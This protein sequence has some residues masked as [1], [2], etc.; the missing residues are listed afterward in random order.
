MKKKLVILKRIS[1]TIFVFVFVYILWSTTYPLKGALPAE[2]FFQ[3]DPLVTIFTSISE[4]VILPGIFLSVAMLL[5]TALF[6]RFFCG[7]VCPLG[8]MIDFV[9]GLRKDKGYN[10]SKKV[11]NLR[12]VK[13]YILGIS[14]VIAFFGIQVVWP[15]DPIVIAARFISLNF[16][17]GLT[18]AVNGVF[19]FILKQL[20]RP[21][22]LL[23]FYRSLKAS[24]LGVEISYFPHTVIIFSFFAVLIGSAWFLKRSWCRVI[25][26]LGALYAVLAKLARLKRYT[27]GCVFCGKCKDKCPMAAINE[28]ITYEKS[29]CILCMDCIYNCPV[30]AT[31][32]SFSNPFFKENAKEEAKDDDLVVQNIKG[33]TRRNLLL[34][35]A[36]GLSP[37]LLNKLRKRGEKNLYEDIIIRPPGAIK[38]K[39]FL[40]RCIRCGNCMKVC[41]T[42]GLQPMVFQAGAEGV[43]TPHFI[44]ELGYCEYN[45]TLCGNVCPTGAIPKLTHSE[46]LKTRLGI[47]KID[48]NICLP[49]VKRQE[50]IVCEEHCPVKNKA[51]KLKEEKIDGKLVLRPYVDDDLCIGCGVCQTKCPVRPVRAIKILPI[52]ADRV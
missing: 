47:A 42:N 2:T 40:N 51:I 45:C 14:G 28:D 15:L 21:Q 33:L 46:K 29:E 48:R 49:W 31:R 52:K 5:L 6:A 13:F 22:L 3:L 41:V 37:L 50:C 20:N 27:Q 10:I 32:F 23:D 38:E 12:A 36:A 43:W 16:I 30:K 39:E 35:L 8:A 25:C 7:W 19:V 18:F 4:R 34:I 44:F 26:P 9:G 17:P 24:L 1:Q 11:K